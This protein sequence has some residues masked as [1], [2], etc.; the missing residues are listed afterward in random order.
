VR[1]VVIGVG[2]GGWKESDHH[3]EEGEDPSES[4]LIED[5]VRKLLMD[6]SVERSSFNGF[7][8]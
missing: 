8:C 2:R 6:V 4:K 5:V 3:W 7:L 1:P